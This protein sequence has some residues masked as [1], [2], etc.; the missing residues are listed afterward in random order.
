MKPKLLN[1]IISHLSKSLDKQQVYIKKLKDA[2]SSLELALSNVQQELQKEREVI[3]YNIE[4]RQ[5]F[6]GYYKS[7]IAR[8]EAISLQITKQDELISTAEQMLIEIKKEQMKF[9]K[10]LENYKALQLEKENKIEA[11]E[12]DEFNTIRFV[13]E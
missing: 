3:S 1:R 13:A 5:Y 2:K 8:Q 12:L 10:L 6:D 4:L 7:N 9:E 11:K